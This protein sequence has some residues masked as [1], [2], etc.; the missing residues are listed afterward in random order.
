MELNKMNDDKLLPILG[1]GKE[2]GI[3]RPDQRGSIA[4]SQPINTAN[5]ILWEL[6]N[7][8][9]DAEQL[10][11]RL[12]M[13]RNTILIFCRCLD[14]LELISSQTLPSKG[15][16]NLYFLVKERLQ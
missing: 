15:S 5:L 11:D 16:K 1:A 12:K 10:S 9:L 14:R 6:Q 7:R 3:L 4:Y 13:A 2:I 8:E